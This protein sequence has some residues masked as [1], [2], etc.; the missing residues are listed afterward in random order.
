MQLNRHLSNES[1]ESD[2]LTDEQVIALA[3]NQPWTD[4]WDGYDFDKTLFTHESGTGN[5]S[6]LSFGEP[7]MPMIEHLKANVASG[8]KCKVFTAR[9]SYAD[10]RINAVVRKHIQAHV[11]KHAGVE[12]E[13]TNIKDVGMRNLF[14]DRAFHVV[15]NKGIIVGPEDIEA[16]RQATAD[17]HK[18]L[19]AELGQE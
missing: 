10:E 7:I 17:F 18:N 6:V 15:P 5:F 8:K 3:N 2:A 14:D 9:V 12:V 13:V 11:L 4:E 19:K 1:L 16:R